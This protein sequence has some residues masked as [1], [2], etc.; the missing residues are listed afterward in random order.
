[1]IS[2]L[3][4]QFGDTHELTESSHGAL[5]RCQTLRA[6]VTDQ[7]MQSTFSQQSGAAQSATSSMPAWRIGQAEQHAPASA[8]TEPLRLSQLGGTAKR[9]LSAVRK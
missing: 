5:V 2:L 1:M 6:Q 3:V 4:Q 8:R 7:S 9:P